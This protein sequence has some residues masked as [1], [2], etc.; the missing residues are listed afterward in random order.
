MSLTL[1]SGALIAI[2]RGNRVLLTAIKKANAKN[3]RVAV[4]AGVVAQVWHDG[5][6]Q[7]ALSRLLKSELVDIVP[8]DGLRARAAGQLCGTTNTADIVG[9]SVVVCARERKSRVVTSDP[10][11]LRRLDPTLELIVV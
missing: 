7:V 5:R 3:L 4:P 6:T 9:A 2:E 8:L 10:A 11:D 1:D